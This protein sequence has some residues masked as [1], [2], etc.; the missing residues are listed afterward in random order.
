MDIKTYGLIKETLPLASEEAVLELGKQVMLCLQ[1]D[2]DGDV[3]WPQ[4]SA[5]HG[6]ELL[7]EI[8]FWRQQAGII[9]IPLDKLEIRD[10]IS[11]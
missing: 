4:I 5:A 2:P 7:R 8:G 10:I 9:K 11:I 6:Q 3:M 1:C